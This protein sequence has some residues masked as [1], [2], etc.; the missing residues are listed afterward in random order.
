LVAGAAALGAGGGPPMADCGVGRIRR[1]ES[2]L[3]DMVLRWWCGSVDLH[4]QCRGGLIPACS[5][6]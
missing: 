1:R 3:G 4:R 2:G 5:K 6:S